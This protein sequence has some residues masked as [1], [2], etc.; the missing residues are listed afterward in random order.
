MK[1]CIVAGGLA[2]RLQPLTS[3]IPKFLVNIGKETG[4]VKMV[5]YWKNYTDEF[6]IIVHSKFEQ[7]TK[8]YF[9]LYFKELKLQ[10]ITVDVALG[11]A[12]TID[13]ALGHDF[14]GEDIL[15]TWC[16][17]IPGG[18]PN[19]VGIHFKMNEN[20][21]TS[22]S[23]VPQIFTIDNCSNRYKFI[24][25]QLVK[26]DGGNV[27]GIYH[28]PN[29]QSL[30]GRFEEGEDFAD[31]LSREKH[32]KEI[33]LDEAVDFGDKEKLYELFKSVDPAREFNS[34]EIF[35]KF[36][37]K[38]ALNE[39][40][41][42]LIK[43]ELAWYYELQA[44]EIAIP[45][46]T[47]YTEIGHHPTEFLMSKIDNGFPLYK[48]FYNLTE[49]EQAW[50]LKDIFLSFDEMHSKKINDAKALDYFKEEAYTK[51]I[52]RYSEIKEVID[53]FGAGIKT[54]NG[55]DLFDVEPEVIIKA[56]YE[57]MLKHYEDVSELSFI[58]GDAQMSNIMYDAT[59]HKI[60]FIDPRGY[61]GR[62]QIYGFADY[63]IGK[64]AYSISGYDFFNYAR[65]F[66]IEDISK[67]SI[68][69]EIPHNQNEISPKALEIIAEK[70]K[71]IHKMWVAVCWVGL[72]QYIRNDPIKSLA[73]HYHGLSLMSQNLQNN[74]E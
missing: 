38:K 70:F 55:V 50:A 12:H 67:G 49:K 66:Y 52:N 44:R 59:H 24:D 65:D 37:Q 22:P 41:K 73:A 63:D 51:L 25:H 43:K 35:D 1:I 29:F 46:P 58:H 61:F 39:Q 62:S 2:T 23:Q 15:F 60:F 42:T 3:Y 31:V 34:V 28:V 20:S 30:E 69:F 64:L 18:D 27:L 47:V 14:D 72:A 53:A 26:E 40:G 19:Y 54:V 33:K 17:V 56:H 71:P 11:S 10:I 16:D 5:R 21:K 32:L 57:K 6:V 48:I 74:R 9:D 13:A 36:V 45:V 4:L 68:K 8:A 7:L